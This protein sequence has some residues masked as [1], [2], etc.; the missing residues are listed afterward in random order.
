ME[1][2]YSLEPEVAGELGPKTI[3]DS[4]VHPPIVSKLHFI[5]SGWLG[6]EIIE[7]FPCYIVTEGLVQEIKKL[8]P[9]GCWFDDVTIEKSEQFNELYP[10]KLLPKFKWLKVEGKAGKDDFGISPDNLL[11]VSERMLKV[12]K[13]FNLN[14]CDITDL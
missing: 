3:M 11:V 14:E 5:F 6:D 1:N 9:S 13:S 10:N 7:C 8:Q 2:F 4:S 12:L